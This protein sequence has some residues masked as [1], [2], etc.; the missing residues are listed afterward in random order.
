M[1]NNNRYKSSIIKKKL[2][3]IGE[4][5]DPNLIDPKHINRHEPWI[6][7]RKISKEDRNRTIKLT[8]KTKI[9]VIKKIESKVKAAI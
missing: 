8:L 3:G 9:I 4:D 5:I 6:T 7:D 1:C 2:K